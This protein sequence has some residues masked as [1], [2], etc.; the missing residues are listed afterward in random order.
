MLF[1]EADGVSDEFADGSVLFSCDAMRERGGGH[2]TRLSNSN[3]AISGEATV[4]DILRYLCDNEESE[5]DQSMNI[6]TSCLS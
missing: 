2:S 4:E 1:I 5:E 3:Y 6:L